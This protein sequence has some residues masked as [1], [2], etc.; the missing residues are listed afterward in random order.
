MIT[1]GIDIGKGRHAVALL[2]E[3]GREIGQARFY[4]NTRQGAEKL[5]ERLRGLSGLSS[6]HVGMESTGNYWRAFHDHLAKA[7]CKVDV[8]NPIIT[9]ASMAGD[10]RGRKT[11]K[12]DAIVIAEVVFR[13]N[14][15]AKPAEN[16]PER[17]LKVLT[18][19]RGF[20]VDECTAVK[21]H[22]LDSLSETFP[23]FESLFEDPFGVLPLALLEKYPGAYALAHAHLPAVMKI[24]KAHT[25]GK[26]VEAEAR[27]LIA[28]A[29]DSIC[30]DCTIHAEL[31]EC[32]RS[33]VK[34]IYDLQ[35]RIKQVEKLIE[36]C[37]PPKVA[38]LIMKIKGSGKLLPKIIAA[39]F[40]DLDR[41][42]KDPK[43]GAE[44]DM[45]KRLLA[46]A[47]SEPRRRESGKWR[48]KDFISK[49]GPGQ[50]RT[51]LYLIGNNIRQWDPNFKEV[52]DRKVAAGKHHNV[53]V[54]YVFAKLLEILSAL[55][56]SG[57]TYT[58]EA[59]M[60]EVI[61]N[62]KVVNSEV[63]KK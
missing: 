62:R 49:R 11:D 38:Q 52:Y 34:T 42:V 31:G 30:I 7:G 60:P 50:L 8:I 23:E 26:D 27:K 39:E 61:N 24:I 51:A 14:Y 5:L 20:L 9:S 10:I 40:G 6:V 4:D 37:E 2:D 53:A 45:H 58:V 21:L 33:S 35:S 44:G 15:V 32:I 55:Y 22:L 3:S 59:P 29:K 57:R 17:G 48:G 54:I 36:D 56:K 47:G 46:Y 43:T 25:R 16:G 28:A 63:S 41:F 12:R 18:R 13:G 1:C 19:Q